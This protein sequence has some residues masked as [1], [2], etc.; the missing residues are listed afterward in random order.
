[1]E[2]DARA[3]ATQVVFLAVCFVA[4]TGCAVLTTSQVQEVKR[5]GDASNAYTQLPGALASSYGALVRDSSL[6]SLSKDTFSADDPTKA[7]KAWDEIV[8][9]YQVEQTFA[10]DGKQM[11]GALSVLG[12][13]SKILSQLV[14]DDYTDALGASTARLG[15]SLDSLT[16]AYN[17]LKPSSSPL[18]SVGGDIAE[19]IRLA[20]GLYIRH[21]QAM[22]LRDTIE[23]ANPLVQG[24]ME[25]VQKIS[26]NMAADYAAY[27]A[28]HL[29]TPFKEV[30]D[31]RGM[32]PVET[33][34][35]VY[36][37]LSRARA[38]EKLAEEV[39]K[40]AVTYAAAHQALFDKTRTRTDLTELIPEIQT[41]LNEV[42]AA[43]DVKAKVGK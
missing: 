24:L 27:E 12:E 20:G 3:R 17:K 21:R 31:K 15:T 5:F 18:P 37:D 13:Y 30:A 4:L 2:C 10:A 19:A 43:Q 42:K 22:V 6:L 25:D 41:F 35:M 38:G 34:A 39:G 23:K 1:M 14:S 26:A 11:D 9:A 36:D 16:D 7:D 33:M 29:E 8:K 28:T 32:L 40:G